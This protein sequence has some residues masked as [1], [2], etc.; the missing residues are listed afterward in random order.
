MVEALEQVKRELGEDAVILNTRELP[1]RRWLPW[2]S[3]KRIE[4]VAAVEDTPKESVAPGAARV[5]PKP[6]VSPE[7]GPGDRAR[8]KFGTPP[9]RRPLHSPEPMPSVV[10]PEWRILIRKLAE[11]GVSPAASVMTHLVSRLVAGGMEEEQAHRL[12]E[13]AVVR[14]PD[15]GPWDMENAVARLRE[16]TLQCLG[17]WAGSP[18]S[19]ASR[20]VAMVGPT[21]VGKTTTI[22]KLAAI[23]TLDEDKRVALVTTD[24]Y[25]IAAVEQLRTYANIIGI[26]CIVVYSPDDMRRAV[27]QLQGFDRIFVDTA[28]R[29]FAEREHVV[30]LSAMLEAADPDETY[31]V[32]SLSGKGSD[33]RRTVDALREI[34]IDKYVFTKADETESFASAVDLILRDARPVS[35]I[36]TGQSV[37][38]DIV[39]ADPSYLVERL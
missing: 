1:V 5:A 29:N 21:G 8:P 32:L 39:E 31:L 6:L 30:H 33:M 36:T 25:R 19:P 14:I 16:V 9:V 2:R 22:A 15:E 34:P 17:D 37:P 4:I 28:G 27:E 13:L 26:P 18:M 10:E 23:Q 24:T 35:Y 20:V 7:G 12:A 11:T 38:D 3:G